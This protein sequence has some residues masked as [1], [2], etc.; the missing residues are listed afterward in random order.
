MFVCGRENLQTMQAVDAR[1]SVFRSLLSLS[2]R[3]DLIMA[4]VIKYFLE[5]FCEC[6]RY[7]WNECVETQLLDMY[8]LQVS[9]NEVP[10]QHEVAAAVVYE[11]SDGDDD[12]GE[13]EDVMD[14]DDKMESESDDSDEDLRN[15]HAPSAKHN[16]GSLDDMMGDSDDDF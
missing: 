9:N 4:Q 8:P 7:F 6:T 1:L 16:N 5:T 2:G 13:V 11:E 12:E 15:G 3:L 10:Q 14:A